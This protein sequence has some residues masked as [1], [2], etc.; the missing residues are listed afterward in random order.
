MAGDY[1][2]VWGPAGVEVVPLEDDDVLIG[3]DPSGQI[4]LGQ[5]P[6]VSRRHAVLERL[7]VG[8]GLRDLSSRNGTVVN[9]ERI[10]SSRA[11]HHRDEIQIGRSRLVFCASGGRLE[12]AATEGAQPPPAL[13]KRE[14]DVLRA[15]F[16]PARSGELF[17]E[18]SSTREM[19]EALCVSEAAVKQHLVHLYDKFG[20]DE[21]ERRRGRL[22]NEALRRGAIRL[23]ELR[24]P[25]PPT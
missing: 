7:P 10:S 6:E 3:R 17:S 14:L 4:V 15:L 18:P 21:G 9:G 25:R 20:I 13:T 22:A 19:A 16:L 2:E 24:S 1:V 5:D 12:V 8:W 11:L 23:S